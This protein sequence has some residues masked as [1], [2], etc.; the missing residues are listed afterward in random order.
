MLFLVPA[1]VVAQ[2]LVPDLARHGLEREN[3]S[4]VVDDPV[5]RRL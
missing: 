3:R 2:K 4:E 1:K 5:G